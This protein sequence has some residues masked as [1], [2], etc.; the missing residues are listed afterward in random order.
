MFGW[1]TMAEIEQAKNHETREKTSKPIPIHIGSELLSAPFFEATVS[2]K[3]VHYRSTSDIG[4]NQPNVL[5]TMVDRCYPGSNFGPS[6]RDIYRG[7]QDPDHGF[8][9]NKWTFL[10]AIEIDTYMKGYGNSEKIKMI[11]IAIYYC[12]MGHI[13]VLAYIPNTDKFFFRFDG[14]S[15]VYDREEYY[16][17]YHGDHFEP[18]RLPMY[19]NKMDLD[20]QKLSLKHNF[21]DQV[22]DSTKLHVLVQY[23]YYDVM[24]NIDPD[25]VCL[26]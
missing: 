10:S 1:H 7:L 23:N 19:H 3:F 5:D 13:L 15:N 18:D 24:K 16:N 25:W 14:G 9:V 2:K 20:K 8:I 17:K 22:I 21:M 6:I 11:D 26:C 12:G 4:N